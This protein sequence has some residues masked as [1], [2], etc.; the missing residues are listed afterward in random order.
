[1]CQERG[2][3]LLLLSAAKVATDPD[4]KAME[5]EVNSGAES[6]SGNYCK[7]P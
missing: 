7:L 2:L 5:F 4:H 3:A 6:Y 1:M